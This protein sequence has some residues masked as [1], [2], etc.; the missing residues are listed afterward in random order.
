MYVDIKDQDQED[1][2]AA[3]STISGMSRGWWVL[4]GWA[5]AGGVWVMGAGAVIAN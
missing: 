3:I 2:Y 1:P 5:K 4:C